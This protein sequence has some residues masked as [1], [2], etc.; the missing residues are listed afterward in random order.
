MKRGSPIGFLEGVVVALA[1]AVGAGAGRVLLRLLFGPE[2]TLA[3][4]ITG[5]GLVYL[6][7]LLARA[8]DRTGRI[9]AVL[10][11]CLIS[12][13]TLILAPDLALPV[14]LVLLW[15][16]RSLYHQQG[17]IG[18]ALDLGLWLLG[19]GGALWAIQGSGSLAL[20]VWTL[21]LIQALFPLIPAWTRPAAV[22]P[23][24]GTIDTGSDRFERAL[25][26]AESSLRQLDT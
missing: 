17:V 24:D 3:L 5:L 19:I 7:Y 1:V 15:L 21:L 10:A 12:A 13:A 23:F 11:W 26:D 20:A 22:D 8:D 25:R 14:Q 9:S 4:M 16:I 6:L 2:Q 18:A